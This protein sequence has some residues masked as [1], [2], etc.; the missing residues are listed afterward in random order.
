MRRYLTLGFMG[1]TLISGCRA[2]TRVAEVPRVDLS[3]SDGGNRGYVVGHPPDEANLKT[4]RQIM[5]TDIEV[6]GWHR[7]GP[8][9]RSR[10]V[11]MP[12]AMTTESAAATNVSATGTPMMVGAD[13]YV[14]QPRDSLW[15][16]A[17][18]PDI[19][20]AATHWRRLFEANR[21][22]LKGNPNGLRVGMTLQIPR[23]AASERAADSGDEGITFKK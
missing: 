10:S 19:Y 3:L 7:A 1:L 17:K 8:V 20:G 11:S 23:S 22:L 13:T 6:S 9:Q 12:A 2:S 4:T 21:D 15:S 14:V 18:K 16:I 5:Q